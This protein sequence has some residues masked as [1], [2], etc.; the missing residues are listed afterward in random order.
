MGPGIRSN[1]Q[2][3][4]SPDAEH[5]GRKRANKKKEKVAGS[6]RWHNQIKERMQDG[7]PVAFEYWSE[8]SYE[9]RRIGGDIDFEWRWARYVGGEKT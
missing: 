6:E 5:W 7:H 2:E 1:C 3:E 4:D 9:K 8:R